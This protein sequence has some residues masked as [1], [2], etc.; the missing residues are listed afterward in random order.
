VDSSQNRQD[1]RANGS[2]AGAF[3]ES[4]SEHRTAVEKHIRADRAALAF[5]L[6][7]EN[8]TGSIKEAMLGYTKMSRGNQILLS[9]LGA[10]AGGSVLVCK[11]NYLSRQGSRKL[12]EKNDVI[13]AMRSVSI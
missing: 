1:S 4:R 2:I 9:C 13:C 5:S 6:L 7:L 10:P 3:S 11:W 12:G 8:V